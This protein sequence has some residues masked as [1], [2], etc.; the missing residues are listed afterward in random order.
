MMPKSLSQKLVAKDYLGPATVDARRVPTSN[1]PATFP[2]NAS[3][4]FPSSVANFGPGVDCEN[5]CMETTASISTLARCPSAGPSDDGAQEEPSLPFYDRPSGP[6]DDLPLEVKSM[7]Q[8]DKFQRRAS[9]VT[10]AHLSLSDWLDELN[11]ESGE[12]A[13]GLN[14]RFSSCDAASRKDAAPENP[15]HRSFVLEKLAAVGLDVGA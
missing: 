4:N 5:L 1:T 12:D 2:Q 6:E 3:P 9:S 10:S 15:E 14:T 13:R 11:S 7:T 8:A